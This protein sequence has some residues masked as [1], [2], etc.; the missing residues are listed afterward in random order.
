MEVKKKA[1]NGAVI[2]GMATIPCTVLPGMFSTERQVLIE[3]PNGQEIDALVDSRSVKVEEEPTAGESVRG[4]VSVSLVHFDPQTRQAL[5]DLPQGSFTRG[6]R[7]QIP[8]T[9]VKDP[10]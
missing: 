6:P 2:R 10:R 3:L 9:M 5:V 4:F 1:K 8:S 7:I